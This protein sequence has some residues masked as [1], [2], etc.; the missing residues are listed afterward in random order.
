MY[1]ANLFRLHYL[2]ILMAIACC[3]TL[4]IGSLTSQEKTPIRLRPE[5][6]NKLNRFPGQPSWEIGPTRKYRGRRG[7]E[8]K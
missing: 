3:K 2:P 7:P 5:S 1:L 6:V 8:P 4:D